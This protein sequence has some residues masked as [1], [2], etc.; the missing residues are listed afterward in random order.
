MKTLGSFLILFLSRCQPVSSITFWRGRRFGRTASVASGCAS[1]SSAR[2][3]SRRGGSRVVE[4]FERF[5][6]DGM[7]HD[8]FQRADHI[9][10]LIGDERKRITSPLGATG[11][12]DAVDVRIGSVRHVVVDDI[13]YIFHICK[14]SKL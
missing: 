4:I 7:S 9:L 13:L 11:A 12:S 14:K 10:I 3:S 6:L 1:A 5:A 8:P 2:T